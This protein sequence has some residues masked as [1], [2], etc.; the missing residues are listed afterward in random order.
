MTSLEHMSR[1][2]ALCVDCSLSCEAYYIAVDENKGRCL[3][4]EPENVFIFQKYVAY[5][6]HVRSTSVSSRSLTFNIRQIL[7]TFLLNH[8]TVFGVRAGLLG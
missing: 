4:E 5:V 8:L 3:L 7:S 1:R 6:I 2:M